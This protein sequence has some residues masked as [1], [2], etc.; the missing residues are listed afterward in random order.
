MNGPRVSVCPSGF[1]TVMVIP[2]HPYDA[3]GAA[4]EIPHLSSVDSPKPMGLGVASAI[5]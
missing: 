5:A 4:S 3:D 1:V 2:D